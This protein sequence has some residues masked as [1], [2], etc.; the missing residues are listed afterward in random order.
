MEPYLETQ[1]GTHL[2]ASTV[3]TNGEETIMLNYSNKHWI[4]VLLNE[5]ENVIHVIQRY[6]DFNINDL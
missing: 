4:I 5:N 2:E 1:V 3:D 6:K